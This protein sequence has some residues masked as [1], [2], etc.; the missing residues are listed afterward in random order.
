M[1]SVDLE[2]IAALFASIQSAFPALAMQLERSHPEVELLLEIPKQPGLSFGVSLNLQGDELHLN[3]GS[4]WLEWF[5]C[6]KHE[7]REAFTEA[8]FGLL[9]GQLRILEHVRGRRAFKAYLQRPT[10]QGWQTIGTS[11]WGFSFFPWRATTRV[12]QNT[13]PPLEPLG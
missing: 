6:T 2:E 7:V 12:L 13:Q 8:A 5:P 9:S 4:F 11:G 1:K 10:P 3:A